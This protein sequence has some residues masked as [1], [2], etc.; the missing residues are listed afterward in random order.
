MYTKTLHLN[1]RIA[2]ETIPGTSIKNRPVLLVKQIIR[3]G[4]K[5]SILVFD[6]ISGDTYESYSEYLSFVK[7][8]ELN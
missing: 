3:S 2:F 7:N 6:L 5:V 4:Q 8:Q 1:H